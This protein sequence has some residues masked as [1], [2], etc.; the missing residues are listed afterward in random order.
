MT[1]CNV[2]KI[3]KT[4]GLLPGPIIWLRLC[5]N[6]WIPSSALSASS[7]RLLGTFESTWTRKCCHTQHPGWGRHTWPSFGC[8]YLASWATWAAVWSS[9]SRRKGSSLARWLSEQMFLCQSAAPLRAIFEAAVNFLLVIWHQCRLQQLLQSMTWQVL[10]CRPSCK[11]L[12]HVHICWMEKSLRESCSA[13]GSQPWS[14]SEIYTSPI[15]NIEAYGNGKA[16]QQSGDPD[17]ALL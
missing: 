14:S 17:I 9:C 2:W 5:P 12:P 15:T 4:R 3:W 1:F 10:P 13:E 8:I 11:C 6:W 7:E 16:L